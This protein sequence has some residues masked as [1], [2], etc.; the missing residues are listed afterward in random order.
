MKLKL[1]FV[2]HF[3]EI[4]SDPDSRHQRAGLSDSDSHQPGGRGQQCDDL[5]TAV[6]L[7]SSVLQHNNQREQWLGLHPGRVL[8]AANSD[9][10]K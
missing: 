10:A 5:L 8:R 2:S 9:S 6:S 7:Q 1:E 4:F 3:I